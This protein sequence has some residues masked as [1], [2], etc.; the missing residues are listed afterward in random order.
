MGQYQVDLVQMMPTAFSDEKPDTKQFTISIKGSSQGITPIISECDIDGTYGRYEVA[1]EA[2]PAHAGEDGLLE[3]ECTQAVISADGI[4]A[5]LPATIIPIRI[6]SQWIR[7]LAFSILAFL[8]L[9]LGAL[10]PQVAKNLALEPYAPFV[11]A[12][13]FTA[14]LM[15]ADFGRIS[16]LIKKLVKP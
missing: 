2:P 5:A 8:A 9:L 16:A 13:C 11:Q 1:F 7:S 3:L 4:S 6:A 12:V 10:T 14:A 15:V